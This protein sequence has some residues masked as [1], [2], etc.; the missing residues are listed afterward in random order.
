M[1]DALPN[2]SPRRLSSAAAPSRR[3][4]DPIVLEL[5]TETVD[6][7]L[8]LDELHQALAILLVSAHQR[9][10]AERVTE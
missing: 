5:V 4:H 6:Q 7:N 1:S 8:D 10:S 3:R 2:A 9:R